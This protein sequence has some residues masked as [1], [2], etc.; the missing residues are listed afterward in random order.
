MTQ[1]SV[2]GK[3]RPCYAG[4]HEGI[5]E[6]SRK[7][8]K[9]RRKQSIQ[10]AYGISLKNTKRAV[11]MVH[12]RTEYQVQQLWGKRL[13]QRPL[14][15]REDTGAVESAEGEVMDDTVRKDRRRKWNG[16]TY[17]K[18]E[19]SVSRSVQLSPMERESGSW[20]LANPRSPPFS[21]GEPQ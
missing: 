13:V 15:K 17:T 7:E 4:R 5:W 18:G 6:G 11:I 14:R 8:L 1:Q 21:N 2:R 9:I 20:L 16:W 3:A 12:L 10:S 19:K